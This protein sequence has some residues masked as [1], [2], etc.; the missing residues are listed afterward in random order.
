LVK[1]TRQ[2]FETIVLGQKLCPFAAPLSGRGN[3]HH[4]QNNPLLRIVA[5]T[6]TIAEQA[7]AD[8]QAEISYLLQSSSQP[9]E[10]AESSG[11]AITNEKNN[12][13]NIRHPIT[14]LVVFDN[15]AFV[16]DYVNFIKL[17]WTLQQACIVEPDL[18]EHLQLV[19]FHPQAVHSTYQSTGNTNDEDAGEYTIRSPYPTVH[20]LREIDVLRAVQSGYPQLD[21]LSQRNK[22][23]LRTHG[24]SK[25]RQRLLDCYPED[26]GTTT[27]TTTP[28]T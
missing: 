17:S 28:T 26:V 10:E 8:L 7:V 14:T 5:S 22:V 24:T 19:F 20:L 18:T 2:W 1:A 11:T 4:N 9:Q 16:K 3:H 25:C 13:H 27:K 15:V 12:N 6:A 23:K 21:T